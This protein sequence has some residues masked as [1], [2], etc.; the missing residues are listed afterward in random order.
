M[1]P[2]EYAEVVSHIPII[3]FESELIIRL[4]RP[5]ESRTEINSRVINRKTGSDR[6][7]W[8][9]LPR[10]RWIDRNVGEQRL[11][12]ECAE[13][14]ILRPVQTETVRSKDAQAESN[15]VIF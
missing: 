15:W 8:P 5:N 4:G 2:P 11:D 6:K 14:G 9:N 10:H 1:R 12:P 13:A 3:A 7:I